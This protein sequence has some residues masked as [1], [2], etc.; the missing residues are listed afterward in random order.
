MQHDKVSK[1]NKINNYSKD[2]KKAKYYVALYHNKAT[3]TSPNTF[4]LFL[5]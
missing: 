4:L 3:M 2:N 5:K 1:G